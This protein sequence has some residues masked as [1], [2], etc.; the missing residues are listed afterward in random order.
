MFSG[1]LLEELC[2]IVDCIGTLLTRENEEERK[3][4]D[5]RTPS[6]MPTRFCHHFGNTLGVI[7]GAKIVKITT[8][9]YSMFFVR[10]VV[11]P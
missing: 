5:L 4:D 7:S 9:I 10:F 6:W 2:V 3:K 8:W 1:C 11:Q